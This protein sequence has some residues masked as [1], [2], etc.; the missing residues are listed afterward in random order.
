MESQLRLL[1][2]L[3]T[4]IVCAWGGERDHQAAVCHIVG[5]KDVGGTDR[6]ACGQ[7]METRL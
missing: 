7:G 4:G 6:G 1:I 3:L 5:G 2:R